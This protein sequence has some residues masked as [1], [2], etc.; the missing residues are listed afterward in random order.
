MFEKN[1]N[2]AFLL[3]FYGVVLSPRTR[4]LLEMYYCDDLSLAE[5]AENVGISRQGARQAIKKGEDALLDLEDKLGLAMRH[6][7]MQKTAK[8]MLSVAETVDKE[9]ITEQTS[10]L[11]RAVYA[12][13][14]VILERNTEED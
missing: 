3:D 6:T 8:A 11:L 4:E 5:I 13:A 2:I 7:R 9:N 14:D 1:L 10:A 12:C